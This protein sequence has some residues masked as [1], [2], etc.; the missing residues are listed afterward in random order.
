MEGQHISNVMQIYIICKKV[1]GQLDGLLLTLMDFCHVS[2]AEMENV[3]KWMRKESGLI[4]ITITTFSNII[5]TFSCCSNAIRTI[6]FPFDTYISSK[7]VRKLFKPRNVIVSIVVLK[8]LNAIPSRLF[9]VSKRFMMMKTC[10][11]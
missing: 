10:F 4:I 3:Q 9:S 11:V 1:F 7:L 2:E 8:A 6:L 5:I